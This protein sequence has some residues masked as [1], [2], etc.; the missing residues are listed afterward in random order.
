[1]QTTSKIFMSCFFC[2][3]LSLVSGCGGKD[4]D[5][6]PKLTVIEQAEVDKI[7]AEHGKGAIYHYLVEMVQS[8]IE[9]GNFAGGAEKLFSNT[10]EETILKYLK[11]FVFAGADV[12][13]TAEGKEGIAGFTP[14]HMATGCGICTPFALPAS[15]NIE[16]VK[17]L[18]SKGANV[19]AKTQ[20]REVK[21]VTPLHGA[22]VMGDIEIAK[23]LIS[24]KA[25]VNAKTGVSGATPLDSAKW[26]V[27][28]GIANTEMVKYLESVGGK[29]YKA[30]DGPTGIPW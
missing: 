7:L 11:Y 29:S 6:P 13:A 10:E 4:D 21:G 5:K 22:A 30:S 1:M 12:N 3:V 23:F 28:S 15:V 8:K 9:R 18:V 24:K 27:N 17:F 19:N 20:D 25:D 26:I 2:F 16:I 14:L